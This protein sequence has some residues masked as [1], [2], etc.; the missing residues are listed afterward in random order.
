LDNQKI[1]YAVERFSHLIDM[2]KDN[3]AYSDYKEGINK[4]LELAK[5]V[6]EDNAQ[7]FDLSGSEDDQ[8]MKLQNLQN[9]Y[10]LLI[11]TLEIKKPNCSEECLKGIHTG[12]EKSKALF[13]EF[14][15]EFV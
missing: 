1:K 12:F 9:E 13:G 3:R 5:D 14:I 7:K 11:D 6:F 4:G 2:N 10:N 8:T 15:K